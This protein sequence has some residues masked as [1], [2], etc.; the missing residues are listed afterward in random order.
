MSKEI[1][2]SDDY[3]PDDPSSDIAPGD[4]LEAATT[5]GGAEVD[6]VGGKMNEVSPYHLGAMRDAKPKP[7]TPQTRHPAMLEFA[8]VWFEA[9]DRSDR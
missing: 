5:V 8:G 4:D 1:H 7:A 2:D 9:P 6:P 3:S